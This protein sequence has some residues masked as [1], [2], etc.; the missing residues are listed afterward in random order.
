MAPIYKPCY[1]APHRTGL[2]IICYAGE[3]AEM[4]F[5]QCFSIIAVDANK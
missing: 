5:L 1:N 3:P 4:A 2:D